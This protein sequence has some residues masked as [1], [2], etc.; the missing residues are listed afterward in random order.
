MT[1]PAFDRW[2][3]VEEAQERALRAEVDETLIRA[4]LELSP[5]ER[6]LRHD[7][8]V[9]LVRALRDAAARRA[10]RES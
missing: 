7:R 10:H 5:L 6:L 3:E 4:N 2:R 8:A 9:G 1:T